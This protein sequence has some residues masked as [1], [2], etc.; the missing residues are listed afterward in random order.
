VEAPEGVLEGV[1]VSLASVVSLMLV[2]RRTTRRRGVVMV[3]A[4]GEVEIVQ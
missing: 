2:A 3:V 1:E 4:L